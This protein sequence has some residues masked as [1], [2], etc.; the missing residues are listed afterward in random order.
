MTNF[1][2]FPIKEK[3]LLK[4]SNVQMFNYLKTFSDHKISFWKEDNQLYTMH[5]FDEGLQIKLIWNML[6][7]EQVG[8]VK[9]GEINFNNYFSIFDLDS[10]LNQNSISLESFNFNSYTVFEFT[11]DNSL[12]HAF[13]NIIGE[14]RSVI[15]E[16]DYYQLEYDV[17]PNQVEENNKQYYFLDILMD[18][19]F[20]S[21]N[22]LVKFRD[23]LRNKGINVE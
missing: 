14:N 16:E 9:K 8:F 18:D 4:F 10:L 1:T 5:R 6:H 23:Y 13:S 2:N 12:Y 20:T 15:S 7:P 11:P 21:I 22:N 19:L 17:A 3:N